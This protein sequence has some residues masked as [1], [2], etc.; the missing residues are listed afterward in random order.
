LEEKEGK[1]KPSKMYLCGCFWGQICTKVV[2]RGIPNRTGP[3]SLGSALFVI[4]FPAHKSMS[5]I[6]KKIKNNKNKHK[7]KIKNNKDNK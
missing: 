3:R 7:H 4:S 2:P 1:R 5:C 6:S